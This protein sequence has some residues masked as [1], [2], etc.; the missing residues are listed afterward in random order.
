LPDRIGRDLFVHKTFLARG[1][2]ADDDS[3]AGI[4]VDE[5]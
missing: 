5:V 2:A 3:E 1:T 4:V